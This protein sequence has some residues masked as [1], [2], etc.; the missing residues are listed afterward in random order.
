[1]IRV[2]NFGYYKMV[3]ISSGQRTIIFSRM[4]QLPGVRWL[5]T[6]SIKASV[7]TVAC[8]ALTM[9]RQQDTQIYCHVY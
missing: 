9:Q 4:T 6:M 5:V 7:A 1:V 8:T 3:G 2:L